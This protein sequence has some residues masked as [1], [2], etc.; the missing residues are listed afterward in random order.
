M[1]YQSEREIIRRFLKYLRRTSQCRFWFG[2]WFYSDYLGV[3]TSSILVSR[4]ARAIAQSAHTQIYIYEYLF[5]WKDQNQ[6]VP[7]SKASSQDYNI[8]QL[9]DPINLPKPQTAKM[10]MS[11]QEVTKITMVRPQAGKEQMVTYLYPNSKWTQRRMHS[12]TSTSKVLNTMQAYAQK[13]QAE[14]PNVLSWHII[15]IQEPSEDGGKDYAV[16]ERQET[17][18]FMTT[19]CSDN[20]FHDYLQIRKWRGRQ[21]PLHHSL[22][23]W[24]EGAYAWSSQPYRF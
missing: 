9:K 2:I 21:S 6:T 3:P 10:N 8:E 15:D 4:Q 1:C 23:C 20:W 19:R 17:P 11:P 5:S 14:D 7:L 18:V 13:V 24:L 12:L 22:L 16:L